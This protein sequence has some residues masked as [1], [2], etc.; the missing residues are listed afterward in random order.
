MRILDNGCAYWMLGSIVE[1]GIHD[2][3]HD[4]NMYRARCLTGG[5]FPLLQVLDDK[6]PE[7]MQGRAVDP[8]FVIWKEI[9]ESA[10]AEEDA[11]V[12]E[13]EAINN[14]REERGVFVII[15]QR[16]GQVRVVRKKDDETVVEGLESIEMAADWIARNECDECGQLLTDDAGPGCSRRHIGAPKEFSF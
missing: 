1:V 16:K 14:C 6:Y 12:A 13:E 9:A 4:P 2:G 15:G 5:T 11:L 7:P 8:P 10:E 3:N